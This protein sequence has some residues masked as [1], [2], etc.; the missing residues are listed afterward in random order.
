[1]RM[2]VVFGVIAAFFIGVL[3]VLYFVAKQANPIMLDET[4]KPL[5]GATSSSHPHD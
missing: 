2:K 5:G 4:G 3:V 1:M